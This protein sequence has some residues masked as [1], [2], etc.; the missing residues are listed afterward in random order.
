MATAAASLTS[1]LSGSRG[2]AAALTD[3][4]KLAFLIAGLGLA[5]ACSSR[6]PCPGPPA[7]SP[8]R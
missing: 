2:S 6:S 7:L 5:A 4:Y 8:P 1:G 3:G